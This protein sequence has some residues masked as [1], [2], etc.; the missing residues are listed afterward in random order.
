[1]IFEQHVIQDV[2]VVG[3]VG[4]AWLNREFNSQAPLTASTVGC[5]APKCTGRWIRAQL[6]SPHA[7]RKRWV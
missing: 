4:Q 5:R 1:M 2:E 3:H 6:A 7:V